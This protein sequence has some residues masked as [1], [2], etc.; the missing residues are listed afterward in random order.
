MDIVQR[1]KGYDYNII[2]N[3]A[4]MNKLKIDLMYSRNTIKIGHRRDKDPLK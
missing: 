1:K 4:L 2:V 3:P